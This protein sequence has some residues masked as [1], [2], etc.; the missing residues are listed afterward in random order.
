MCAWLTGGSF[1]CRRR[2]EKQPHGPIR[3]THAHHENAHASYPSCPASAH[4]RHAASTR[5]SAHTGHA[6]RTSARVWTARYNPAN[7]TDAAGKSPS[8]WAPWHEAADAGEE[9]S[10]LGAIHS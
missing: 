6:A 9:A 5:C 10:P 8:L 7:Q 2:K 4:T 3:S 1:V